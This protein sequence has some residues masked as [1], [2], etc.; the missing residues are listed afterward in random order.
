MRHFLLFT[1]ISLSFEAF[2]QSGVSGVINEY[3]AIAAANTYKDG[4]DKKKTVKRMERIA[5]ESTTFIARMEAKDW[6]NASKAVK[7][8]YGLDKSN[9]ALHY[10]TTGYVLEMKN[11]IDKALKIYKRAISRYKDSE[12]AYLNMGHIYYNRG[13]E[14]L[15]NANELP[16][17]QYLIERAKSHEYLRQA[18]PLFETAYQINK[19]I[20]CLHALRS[21]YYT[22]DMMGKFNEI[23]RMIEESEK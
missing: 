14:I 1:L 9:R 23:E 13:L 11:E 6:N 7:K 15:I 12:W 20:D 10:T 19:D 22:L 21:I 4:V 17:E 16:A 18:M 3:N 5:A 8:L 2:A